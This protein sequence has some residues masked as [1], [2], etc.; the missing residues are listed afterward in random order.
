MEQCLAFCVTCFLPCNEK[1]GQVGV[2]PARIIPLQLGKMGSFVLYCR[3]IGNPNASHQRLLS[4]ARSCLLNG[5][6]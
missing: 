2:E 4:F 6:A 5:V 3:L 1:D